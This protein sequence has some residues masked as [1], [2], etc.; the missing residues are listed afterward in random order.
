MFTSPH[1]IVC[2]AMLA[3]ASLLGSASQSPAAPQSQ[4]AASVALGRLD[5]M[6]DQSE[7]LLES[8]AP[9]DIDMSEVNDFHQLQ[10]AVLRYRLMLIHACDMAVAEARFC[11]HPYAPAWLEDPA[12]RQPDNAEL[13]S[14]IADAQAHIRPFWMSVCARAMRD[15]PQACESE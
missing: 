8:L 7:G 3:S 11:A 10:I 9:I 14:R 12:D 6:L 2:A 13:A 15:N 1:L 5:T 4:S